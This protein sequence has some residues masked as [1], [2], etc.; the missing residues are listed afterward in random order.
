MIEPQNSEKFTEL[1]MRE[2]LIAHKEMSQQPEEHLSHRRRT[3]MRK[4][5]RMIDDQLERN[6]VSRWLSS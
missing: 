4:F 3:V 1:E 2:A 6:V 5:S